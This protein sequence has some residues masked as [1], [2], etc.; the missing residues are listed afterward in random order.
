MAASPLCPSSSWAWLSIVARFSG[1]NTISNGGL[2]HI[3]LYIRPFCTKNLTA[4]FKKHFFAEILLNEEVS[5]VVRNSNTSFRFCSWKLVPTNTKE[6]GASG[7]SGDTMIQKQAW[8]F[9]VYSASLSSQESSWG[10]ILSPLPR[11]LHDSAS[12]PLNLVAGT[13]LCLLIQYLYLSYNISYV[14]YIYFNI[15][16]LFLLIWDRSEIAIK[17]FQVN[18][19]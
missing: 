6:R 9:H 16:T 12:G 19:S 14:S 13:W 17:N 1:S 10:S 15:H 7:L 11:P 8:E 5:R 18:K 3:L 2:P 4:F